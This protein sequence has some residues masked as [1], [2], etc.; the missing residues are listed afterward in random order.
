MKYPRGGRTR[1]VAIVGMA[2]IA[3]IACAGAVATWR[4][5]AALSLRSTL[6]NARQDAA[7]SEQLLATFLQERLAVLNYMTKP[8]PAA[9]S[10]IGS[11]R[12]QFQDLSGGDQRAGTRAEQLALGRVVAGEAQYHALFTKLIGKADTSHTFRGLRP[13]YAAIGTLEAAGAGVPPKIETL[14]QLQNRRVTMIRASAQSATTQAVVTGIVAIILSILAGIAFLLYAHRTIQTSARRE[15][16]LMETLGHLSDR[17]ALLARLRA[18]AVVLGEVGGELRTAARNAAAA[19]SEQSAAVAQTSA[20]IEQLAAT[21]GSI[22]DNVHAVASAAERTGETMSDVQEKVEAIAA[23]ALSLGERAQKIGE[24]LELINEIAGQTNLLALNAA[25]EAARAGEAGR[26]FAVVAAEVRKLAERS[27]RSTDSIRDIISGV[28]D[29][30]NATIMATEQGTRQAREVGE[31]MASTASMLEE[32]ILATQQQ[33]SAADQVE[34]AI[35]QIRQAADQLAAE[36]AQR[37]ATAERLEALVEEIGSALKDV[38]ETAGVAGIPPQS[39]HVTARREAARQQALQE[40]AQ[41]TARGTRAGAGSAANGGSAG[42]GGVPV[43]AAQAAP[44]PRPEAPGERLCAAAA[45]RRTVRGPRHA[46][47]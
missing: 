12:T 17:N 11:L 42:N 45:G 35:Q 32:S 41:R 14:A 4:Y 21:A 26:G 13:A 7:D 3:V 28:Q 9:L 31:L 37:V 20:T 15:D 22:A 43:P 2:I 16:E 34:G 1:R 38:P 30:T 25:I 18:A 10:A 6:T 5:Q 46:R 44:P 33:K 19:T 39:S 8:S 27:V 40:A 36:Q 23:R 47:A 24:M 29:E